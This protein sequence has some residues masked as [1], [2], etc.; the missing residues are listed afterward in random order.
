MKFETLK[1]LSEA[2]NL[3]INKSINEEGR[4]VVLDGAINLEKY[5]NS[6]IKIMWILKEPYDELDGKGGGFSISDFIKEDVAYEEFVKS[7]PT[8]HVLTYISYGILNNFTKWSQM[9]SLKDNPKMTNALLEIA[10]IN[11]QK[12]PSLNHSTTNFKDIENSFK[13]YKDL[14]SAQIELLNPDVIIGGNTMSL[15]VD[16]F[17]LRDSEVKKNGSLQYWEKGDKLY[18]DAYHPAIRKN[19]GQYVDEIIT[20]VENWNKLKSTSSVK[21]NS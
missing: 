6:K 12:L 1:T 14:L 8:W 3:L 20:V 17:G 18:I 2:L 7:F 19:R 4:E 11:T 5:A 16:L 13:K 9:D 15:Y 21:N 10:L